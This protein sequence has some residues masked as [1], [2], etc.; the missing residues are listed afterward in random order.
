MIAT[1][2]IAEPFSLLS[3]ATVTR[4]VTGYWNDEEHRREYSRW[5]EKHFGE[6]YVWSEEESR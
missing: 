1:Y 3:A 4:M 6:P 2:Q 5:Y